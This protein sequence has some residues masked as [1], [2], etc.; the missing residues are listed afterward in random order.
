MIFMDKFCADCIHD[1]EENEK[2]CEILTR[3]F[4]FDVKDPEY[5]SEWT[6]D[7]DGDPVCTAFCKEEPSVVQEDHPDQLKLL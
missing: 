5:P 2:Y 4:A 3:T 7:E 6:F 1:D